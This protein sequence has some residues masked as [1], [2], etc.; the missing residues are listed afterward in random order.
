MSNFFK[1][2][3]L[4]FGGLIIGFGL[5]MVTVNSVSLGSS[6]YWAA[7]IGSLILGGFLLAIGLTKKRKKEFEEKLPQQ[8]EEKE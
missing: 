8:E 7:V 6:G 3:L 2:L 4:I 1:I 5:G